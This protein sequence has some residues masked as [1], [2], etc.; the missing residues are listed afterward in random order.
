MKK[1]WKSKE[2]RMPKAKLDKRRRMPES[3]SIRLTNLFLEPE[4]S[5]TALDHVN[6][7]M[8]TTGRYCIPTKITGLTTS[9]ASM[10]ECI[11]TCFRCVN[12]IDNFATCQPH[13]LTPQAP[14]R[15]MR[16]AVGGQFRVHTGRTNMSQEMLQS[17]SQFARNDP[18][19]PA[20]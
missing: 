14:Q 4:P 8:Y 5:S 19:R 16:T 7:S 3:T 2:Q 1:W 10:I 20:P 18:R 17:V 12:C 13:L 9:C 15:D 11:Q 6:H